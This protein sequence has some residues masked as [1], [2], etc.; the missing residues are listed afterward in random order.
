MAD[1]S[2]L[3]AGTALDCPDT[4]VIDVGHGRGACAPQTDVGAVGS[5][6][7]RASS[8]GVNCSGRLVFESGGA[9]FHVRAI[10]PFPA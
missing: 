10:H 6:R 3:T 1:G 5:C 2:R 4:S 9:G 8:G 7:A